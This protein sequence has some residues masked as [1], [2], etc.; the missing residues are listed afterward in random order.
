MIPTRFHVPRRT[1][2]PARLPSAFAYGAL[3]LCGRPSNAVL[4]ASFVPFRGPTT[5]N[6]DSVWAVPLSLAATHGITVVFFSSG[7]LDVSV[8][9]VAPYAAMCSPRGV[10]TLLV[11]GSPIRTPPDRCVLTAPRRVSPLTASFFS[12]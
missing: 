1:Q 8:P 2:D 7:Y 9:R 6:Q 3:T 11:T 4:L 10:T 5:P 12:S